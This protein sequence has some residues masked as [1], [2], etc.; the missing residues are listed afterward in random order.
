MHLHYYDL[1]TVICSNGKSHV[2][3]KIKGLWIQLSSHLLVT[4]EDM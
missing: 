4:E 2:F 3:R 1:W